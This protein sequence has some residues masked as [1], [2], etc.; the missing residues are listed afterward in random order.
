MR[1]TLEAISLVLLAGLVWIT[2]RALYGPNPLP[3]SIPTH[4]DAAG[5]PNGWGPPSTLLVL[6]LVAV[7][8]SLLISVVALFPKMFSYPVR[9]TEQNRARL[10]ALTLK[11]VAWIKFELV[12]LLTLIQWFIL[13]FARVGH[14]TL[15]P[16][17][18]GVFLAAILGTVIVYML[19]IV[20]A[21][22]PD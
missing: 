16:A 19:A 10:E 17:I 20:R 18:V 21:A 6:P 3:A 12:C 15:S 2:G 5:N 11:M 1:K 13:Q 8:L 9:V 4:F 7:G 14:G 22:R